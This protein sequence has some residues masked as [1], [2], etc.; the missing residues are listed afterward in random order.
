MYVTASEPKKLVSKIK[1]ELKRRVKRRK[2]GC[3]N[4]MIR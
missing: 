3:P 4:T 1:W 2:H